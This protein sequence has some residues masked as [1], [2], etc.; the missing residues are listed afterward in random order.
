[1]YEVNVKRQF[2]AAHCLRDVGGKCEE[3]HGHNFSVEVSV[4]GSLLDDHGLLLDF[5]LLKTWLDECLADLDHRYL[6]E[7]QAFQGINPSAETIAHHLYTRLSP[8]AAERNLAVSRVTIWESD[9][10]WVSY[11]ET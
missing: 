3:L 2:S 11:T 7:V 4:A 8:K 5:R 6:N 1:V 10:A 9:N